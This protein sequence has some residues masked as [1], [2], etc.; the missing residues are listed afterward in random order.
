MDQFVKFG[1]RQQ[2]RRQE[3]ILAAADIIK[4]G[5]VFLCIGVTSEVQ[6]Y[7]MRLDIELICGF[8]VIKEKVYSAQRIKAI[9]GVEGQEEYIAGWE[10]IEP[11]HQGYKFRRATPAE[12]KAHNE[13]R[14]KVKN[15]PL[16]E[17]E[18]FKHVAG[19]DTY[20]KQRNCLC[21]ME[22]TGPGRNDVEI[23]FLKSAPENE[24][25]KVAI[26]ALSIYGDMKVLAENNKYKTL[27]ELVEASKK[28]KL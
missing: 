3:M 11:K 25:E 19:V 28:D 6:A 4:A 5:Q 7:A 12:T 10:S 15:Y 18:M 8:H 24:F 1:G 26:E 13:N 14:D 27:A 17:E 22:R 23:V 9:W 20:D 2:G 21:I 16:T